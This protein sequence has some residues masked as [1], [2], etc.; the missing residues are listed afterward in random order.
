MITRRMPIS[1]KMIE[2]K[3]KG[4]SYQDIGALAGVSRQRVHQ[5][6]SGYKC[7][8]NRNREMQLLYEAILRRDNYRCQKCGAAVDLV[9]HHRDGDDRNN[10]DSNLACLC[11]PC[12]LSLHRPLTRLKQAKLAHEQ[13]A[14]KDTLLSPKR[15]ADLLDVTQRDLWFLVKNGELKRII[16][17]ITRSSSLLT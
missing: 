16:R 2:L 1:Q 8:A 4:K 6:I 17:N 3:T 10:R 7:P 9:V 15:A 13:N 11:N 5:L 12:H 14:K